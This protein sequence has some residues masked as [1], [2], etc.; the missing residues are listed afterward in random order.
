MTAPFIPGLELSRLFYREQV[1]PLLDAAYPGLAHAAALAGRGSDVLGFDTPRST[2]HDWGPRLQVL[3]AGPEPAADIR[4]MLAARLPGQFRGF[5]T[6][7]PASGA[8]PETATHWVEVAALADWLT[9]R[10]GFDPRPGVGL[11]DWLATPTQVLAEVTA[12]QVFHDG[13]AA[14]PGGGL[15]AARAALRW[16][17]RDVWL[18]V[19]ACQWQRI[20]QE[21]PF[22]GRC[23]E[24]GDELGSALLAGRLVRDLMRLALLMQRRYPPYSKWLGT[25]FART[26]AGPLLGPA[27]TA[28]VSAASWPAREDALCAAYEATAR[29]HNELN[30]T[31]P[32]DPVVRP[33]FWDRPFRVL[34]AGRFAAALRAQIADP[35]IRDLSRAGAVD[36]F[37]DSTDALGDRRLLRAAI[38]AQLGFADAGPHG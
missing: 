33:A 32:L 13:L 34:G 37:T 17:P 4:A 5:R 31:S 22:P 28:A 6:V 11:A 23:A 18:H 10:L 15:R 20:D 2:D 21:E 36:Q 35:V 9:G 14:L 25:A 16:Y 27:L 24:V 1:R 8:A 30:L 29:L 38:A 19:L 7:F 3:L 12:G 26:P